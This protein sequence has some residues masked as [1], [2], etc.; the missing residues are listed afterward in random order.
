MP[1]TTSKDSETVQSQRQ[2]MRKGR[3][4]LCWCL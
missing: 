4:H 3:F 1:P 2:V